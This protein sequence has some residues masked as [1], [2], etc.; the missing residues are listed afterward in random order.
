[1]D[2]LTPRRW[3]D[4]TPVEPSPGLIALTGSHL[5]A[6]LLARRGITDPAR[7]RAFLS[8][9]H[10]TP[11]PSSALP[12]MAAATERILRAV[13]AGEEICVWGDFDVDG[14]TS[15]TI[16]VS[17]LRHLNAKV[18]HYIPVRAVESHGVHLSTL[19]PLV[20]EGV[21]LLITCD[22][23]ISAVNETAWAKANGVDV[24]ITDHH[25]L[26][27]TLPPADAILN[28]R[29][30]PPDHPLYPLPGCGVAYKL[31]EELLTRS[32]A[33]EYADSLLDLVA[34][35]LVA[36]AA[37]LRAE[38]RYL[39][40]RGLTALRETP[41]AGLRSLFEKSC[42]DPAFI[43]E[44]TI[45]FA[46]APRL[47]A[48]GR[49]ADANPIVDFFTTTSNSQAAFMADRLEGLNNQRRQSCDQIFHAAVEQTG[50]HPELLKTAALVLAHPGWEAGV[51]GIVASRLVE[52]FNRPVILFRAPE[53]G[54][55]RGSARSIP[56]INIT[57]AIA[58]QAEMLHGYGG[59]PMAAGLSLPTDLLADFRMA[60]SYAIQ[61]QT[62]G[63][64][65]ENPLCLD[66]DLPLS[67]VYLDTARQLEPL[68]PFGVGNPAPVFLSAS[69][70]VSKVMPIGAEKEHQVVRVEDEHKGTYDVLRWH[71][72]DLPLPE[73]AFDLAYTPR[74]STYRGEPHLQLEWV[75]ARPAHA[76]S[77]SFAEHP[78]MQVEDLRAAD[79]RAA[80]AAA[81][82]L[83]DVVIWGEACPDGAGLDRTRLHH[84]AVLVFA[85]MPPGAE[86]IKAVMTRVKP[87]R[88]MLLPAPP[89][90]DDPDRLL[91]NLMTAIK[92]RRSADKTLSLEILAGMLG[93]REAIVRLALEYLR[94]SSVL[95]FSVGP[96]GSL[97]LSKGGVQSLSKDGALSLSKDIGQRLRLALE[98]TAAF[99]AHF[100][101]A[102]AA[103]LLRDYLHF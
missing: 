28:P 78:T 79:R 45:G 21:K 98:E 20:E 23:G 5:A 61:Q 48:L 2:E 12:D 68:A 95:D 24:V 60:I 71:G 66:A 101:S 67:K 72:A 25:E 81:A 19:Q 99:R 96:N 18:R 53:G 47:N 30:L 37:E 29:L 8:P 36:D 85:F 16:L 34:L 43:T 77:V 90:V 17:T 15:T 27:E 41:R 88:V 87:V 14:Q 38:C 89:S 54:T 44:E 49:L 9:Q 63:A 50:S 58:S 10:Y 84:A 51:I 64:L 86:E 75:D 102:P 97:R 103:N 3:L 33:A 76:S 80:L 65:L 6:D 92:E 40:Q 57:R 93:Q 100:A 42:V 1:M 26:P 31:A 11:S 73:G 46:I 62:G 83:P 91:H 4:P 7:V 13:Q 59:H 56:G 55:A 35:G 82:A 70:R 94:A 32:G 69:H 52:R 22:T 39:L 74:A